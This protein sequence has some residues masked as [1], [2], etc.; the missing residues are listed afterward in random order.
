MLKGAKFSPLYWAVRHNALIDLQRQIG[1]PT[2]FFTI[3]PYEWSFP[4]HDWV[5]DEMGK[6]LRSRLHLPAG[7]TL[8]ITHVFKELVRG[9][10]T[11][12]NQKNTDPKRADRK[13]TR[14]ILGCKDGSGRETVVNFF[15]RFE[16]Q[17]GKRKEGTQKYHG[18]GTP[19]LHLLVWNENIDSIKLEDSVS[20]T[21]PKDDPLV[22]AYVTADATTHGTSVCDIHEGPSGWDAE[23]KKF[24]LHHTEEDYT[25]GRRAYFLDLMDALK[26]HQDIQ[27]TDS[28]RDGRWI[29]G[30]YVG[31]YV[32]KFSDSMAQETPMPR[33]K[34]SEC[35]CVPRCLWLVF[36]QPRCC[37][38]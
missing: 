4:Y 18:R 29:L 16:F 27:L 34:G 24:R 11:G 15:G 38:T 19:H 26:C 5:L 7:E 6:S 20:A 37:D 30:R 1:Y 23:E 12:W 10:L 17:D 33:V 22:A 28:D 13:W 32:A 14:H 2:L 3:A 9:L 25:D 31:T 21:V 8:H 35:V 36:R